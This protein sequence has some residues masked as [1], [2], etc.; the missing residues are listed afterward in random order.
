ML[1]PENGVATLLEWAA[2]D[3]QARA[4]KVAHVVRYMV[5]AGASGE[6]R[7]SALALALI[8]IAADPGSVLRAVEHRFVIGAGWGPFSP[9]FVRR[10]PLFAGTLLHGDPGARAWAPE[11]ALRPTGTVGGRE[12]RRKYV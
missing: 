2:H 3:P 12:R 9:R 1:E 5:K 10:R 7:W 4:L 6:L 8:D 11:A